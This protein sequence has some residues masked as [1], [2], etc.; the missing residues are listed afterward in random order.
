MIVSTEILSAAGLA[1]G[2]GAVGYL[3]RQT[4]RVTK[5]EERTEGQTKLSDFRFTHLETALTKC[6]TTVERLAQVVGGING[7][8]D[9]NSTMRCPQCD[10]PAKVPH[11]D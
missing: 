7:A 3:V 10:G 6:V 9:R 4:S 8:G 5:L 1:I 2:S 11:A